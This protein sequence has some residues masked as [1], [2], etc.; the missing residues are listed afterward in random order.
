MLHYLWS[1]DPEVLRDATII[2]LLQSDKN[3]GTNVWNK[4]TTTF[5]TQ[6]PQTIAVK[7]RS[8]L[9]VH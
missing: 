6:I 1:G 5:M 7:S 8:M 3:G 2:S 9:S 4:K